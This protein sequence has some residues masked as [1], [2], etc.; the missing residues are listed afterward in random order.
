MPQSRPL[1]ASVIRVGDAMMI[2]SKRIDHL[3]MERDDIAARIEKFKATQE[4][5]A[6]ER[7]EYAETTLQ[8]LW[9]KTWA[10]EQMR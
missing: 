9:M 4:R 5:F 6:R 7:E 1:I 8:K 3:A 10:S 2:K